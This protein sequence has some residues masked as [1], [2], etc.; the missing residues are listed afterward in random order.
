MADIKS[1]VGVRMTQSV[2]FMGQD[3]KI[4]KLSV[5][6]VMAIQEAAKTL[7]Q[8]ESAGLDVLKSVITAAV[9]GAKDLTDE[10]F[11]GFPM[12]ELSKLSAAIMKFSGIGG[13]QGK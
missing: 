3:I 9:E 12:D 1:L 4:S 5:R 6:E 2:K 13:E 8:D 10:D 11:R 7:E